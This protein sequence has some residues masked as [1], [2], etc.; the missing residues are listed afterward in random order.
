M[1]FNSGFKGLKESW[2]KI[3]SLTNLAFC[4][5]FILLAGTIFR[6]AEG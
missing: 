6:S 5:P 4:K 1:E 2:K 3:P